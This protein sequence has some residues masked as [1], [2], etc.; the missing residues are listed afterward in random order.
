MIKNHLH[1]AAYDGHDEVVKTLL[2][3]SSNKKNINAKDKNGWAPLHCA[4]ARGHLKVSLIC[5]CLSFCFLFFF[6]LFF[7]FSIFF[8]LFFFFSFSSFVCLCVCAG[9]QAAD[10]RGGR[11]DGQESGRSD[12]SALSGPHQQ[13]RQ[14]QAVCGAPQTRPAQ[15]RPGLKQTNKEKNTQKNTKNTKKEKKKEKERKRGKK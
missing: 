1:L 8:F 7:F 6:S 14:S 11:R 4:A 10:Q 5:L 9:V 3:Q 13:S 2:K 15:G 12:V